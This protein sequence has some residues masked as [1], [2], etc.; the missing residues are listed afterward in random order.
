M[1]QYQAIFQRFDVAFGEI[2]SFLLPDSTSIQDYIEFVVRNCQNSPVLNEHL[3]I[4]G[5]F[6]NTMEFCISTIRQDEQKIT[7]NLIELELLLRKTL[8][9]SCNENSNLESDDSNVDLLVSNGR[10]FD[11]E[12]LLNNASIIYVYLPTD[13][14]IDEYVKRK[15]EL[16]TVAECG[17]ADP[18]LRSLVS[19]FQLKNSMGV[20]KVKQQHVIDEAESLAYF[21]DGRIRKQISKTKANRRIRFK[22]DITSDFVFDDL[23]IFYISFELPVVGQL[24]SE[25]DE[26]G[27]YLSVIFPLVSL[28]TDFERN[29]K[30]LFEQMVRRESLLF[31]KNCFLIESDHRMEVVS[32]EKDEF[33]STLFQTL[34]LPLQFG[35][36]NDLIEPQTESA[37]ELFDRTIICK[38]FPFRF[39]KKLGNHEMFQDYVK[40]I[41]LK[42]RL[43]ER[44]Q[45]AR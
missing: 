3:D 16:V 24:T 4:S 42:E 27:L 7:L 6:K 43:M 39:D 9:F 11:V 28:E 32:V 44:M 31:Y 15:A 18:F 10:M 26:I 21:K 25:K 17:I 45:R 40:L 20:R 14:S 37:F 38:K 12:M 35:G 34:K 5:L 29:L 13:V 33:K 23:D 2:I 19:G 30:L 36:E 41:L 22:W 1:Q 8:H